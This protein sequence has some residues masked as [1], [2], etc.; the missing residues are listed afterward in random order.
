MRCAMLLFCLSLALLIAHE[1]LFVSFLA[2]HFHVLKTAKQCVVRCF[3][4]V[5]HWHY[6]LLVKHGLVFPGVHKAMHP[7]LS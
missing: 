5:L 2:M 3:F 4:S 1:A 7:H 6:L